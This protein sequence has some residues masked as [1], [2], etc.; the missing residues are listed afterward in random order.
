LLIMKTLLI[1]ICWCILFVLSWPL[2]LLVLLLW[3]VIWLLLLPFRLIGIA[4]EGVFALL[5]A[6]V[7]LPARLLGHRSPAA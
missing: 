4:F 3:P 6:I 2:A 1:A 7:L 5:R